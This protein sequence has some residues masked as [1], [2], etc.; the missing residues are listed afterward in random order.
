MQYQVYCIPTPAWVYHGIPVYMYVY[1]RDTGTKVMTM[2]MTMTMHA[3]WEHG[4]MGRTVVQ[5]GG[6]S[7]RGS[8]CCDTHVNSQS[9]ANSSALG[10]KVDW[11]P[12]VSVGWALGRAAGTKMLWLPDQHAGG[13]EANQSSFQQSI[14]DPLYPRLD[15]KHGKRLSH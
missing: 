7:A 11:V 10:G 4:K 14:L 3:C 8:R 12:W 2:T 9:M 15:T 6:G 1:I 13:Q 5:V